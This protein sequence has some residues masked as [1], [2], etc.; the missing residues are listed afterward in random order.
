MIARPVTLITLLFVVLGSGTIQAQTG[1]LDPTFGQGGRVVTAF[2][3]GADALQDLAVA[4]DGT[5]VAVG[6]ANFPGHD[7]FVV[8]RYSVDGQLIA[9]V[10]VDLHPS[11]LINDEAR[12]VAILPDGRI[13]VAGITAS[14]HAGTNYDI[15]LLRLLPTLAPDPA[16]GVGGIVITPFSGFSNVNGLAIQSDERI[17]VSGAFGLR[18]YNADGSVDATFGANG[19]V[20]PVF[21]AHDAVQGLALQSDGRI[22]VVGVVFDQPAS[23]LSIARFL[24]NGSLDASFGAGGKVFLSTFVAVPS[25]VVVQPDGRI[26]VAGTLVSAAP[27]DFVVWRLERNGQLDTSFGTN[28][29]VFTDVG[30]SDT[31]RDVALQSDGRIVVAG[32]T[33]QIGSPKS[34]NFAAARYEPTGELDA[35]FGDGGLITTDFFGEPDSA[36]AVVI[37]PGRG[38][39][40]G[41]VVGNPSNGTDDFGMARYDG[42]PPNR[43]PVISTPSAS[44]RVLW[45]PNHKFVDVAIAYQVS[46]DQNPAPVCALSATSNEPTDGAGDGH[47]SPDWQIAGTHR[48]RLRAERAGTGTGRVYTVAITCTDAAGLQSQRHLL[49]TVPKSR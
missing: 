40:A 4:P 36:N 41:G 15:A 26:V 11:E 19:L 5:L 44:P 45:P 42:L 27:S 1:S 28:G 9:A 24:S 3:T 21:S 49:V 48:V 10:T 23:E 30:G 12:R 22:L 17:I 43:P 7:D 47:T 14:S 35:T 20:A 29:R 46:D 25:A 13:V 32:L 33:L 37:E 38:I 6:L 8:A 39:V 2:G 16:F 34:S 18:R 31:A